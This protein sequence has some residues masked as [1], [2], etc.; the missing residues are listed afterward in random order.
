MKLLLF[1]GTSEGNHIAQWLA[2]RNSCQ[3]TVCCATEYGGSLVPQSPNIQVLSERMDSQEMQHLMTRGRFTC[4]IDATHPYASIVSENIREAANLAGIRVV[5]V[6]RESEPEGPWI[7][8]SNAEQAA[9]IAASL[10]GNILL[11]T[12][13]KELGVFAEHIPDFSERVFARILPVESSVSSA[14]DLGLPVSHIIAMQGPFSR[15]MNDAIIKEFGINVMITKASGSTGGF[16]EKVDA[17]ADCEV[18]LIVIHRPMDDNEEGVSPEKAC[19]YLQKT[20]GI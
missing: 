19:A 2:N 1:S 17:A 20:F 9:K 14:R 5:R 13:A 8:A 11:T 16:W 3:V 12:G 15:R 4:V 18:E 6:C 7:G 10:S